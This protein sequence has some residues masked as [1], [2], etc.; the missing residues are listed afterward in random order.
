MKNVNVMVV[1]VGG[2]G[3]VLTTQ[4]ICDAAFKAG[5]DMKSNDVIGLSQRGG[6]IWGSVRMGEAVQSP[7]ISIGEGHV[8]IAFEPLE[9][10][11][12]KD[13]LAPGGHVFM[14]LSQI[15]PVPVMHETEKYPEDIQRAL[16]K[17]YS[18]IALDTN[19]IA[20]DIGTIKVSN[21]VL[22]G[23]AARVL[24]IEKNFWLAAIEDNVPRKFL[25]ENIEA[26]EWGYAFSET[27]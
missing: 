17:T 18:V 13:Y 11:R 4:L 9:A 2:Q 25:K 24:P 26:F 16:S 20:S 21:M 3:L 23:L 14:N 27:Q 6:K 10:L 5:L 7:N 12:W 8:L 19:R 22:V 1:G 15:P